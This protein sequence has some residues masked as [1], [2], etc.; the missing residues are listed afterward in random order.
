MALLTR[1]DSTVALGGA[2]ILVVE[3][4]Y[5]ISVELGAMLAAAGAEVIGP[6][7][8][9]AQARSLI[10]EDCI[11]GAVL[12]FRLGRDTT[13]P[14][15]RQLQHRGIPFL[16]FTGQLNTKP[17]DAEYPDAKVISKPFQRQ[18]MLA[19]IADML[20]ASKKVL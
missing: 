8:T 4:D 17:I 2:R 7:H 19:A 10:G 5:I 14:V 16:F 1:S 9:V 3:D 6:C 12:D 18:A 13:L 15:A 20:Q 11:S